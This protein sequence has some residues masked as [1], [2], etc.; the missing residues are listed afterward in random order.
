MCFLTRAKLQH[1]FV[2]LC[3]CMYVCLF[4]CLSLCF[5]LTNV[6]VYNET[7]VRRHGGLCLLLFVGMP[8]DS[9]HTNFIT[10][11]RPFLTVMRMDIT[12]TEMKRK[13]NC[14]RYQVLHSTH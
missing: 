3:V 11:I 8:V 12:R 4:V 2:C 10:H 1:V 6:D 9:S 14:L 13:M 7:H 5:E